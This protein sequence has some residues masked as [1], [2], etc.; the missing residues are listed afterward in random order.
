MRNKQKFFG[1]LFILLCLPGAFL[2]HVV[3]I[4]KTLLVISIVLGFPALLYLAWSLLYLKGHTGTPNQRKYGSFFFAGFLTFTVFVALSLIN[5]QLSFSVKEVPAY[6]INANFDRA[7]RRG[8]YPNPNVP[9]TKLSLHIPSENRDIRV[10]ALYEHIYQTGSNAHIKLCHHIG[11]LGFS[12]YQ[13]A[14][15]AQCSRSL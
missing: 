14:K 11:T 5:Q 9:R 1:V 3:Y 13:L 8:Y 15:N 4:N 6:L 7:D 10:V 2:G 12:Y